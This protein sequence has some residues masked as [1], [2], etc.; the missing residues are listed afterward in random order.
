MDSP[1]FA[2][3][4]VALMLFFLLV[5]SH[6]IV[7][8]V[9]RKY[10]LR[11]MKTGFYPTV[12]VLLFRKKK[13]NTAILESIQKKNMVWPMVYANVMTPL[14]QGV[15]NLVLKAEGIFSCKKSDL[16]FCWYCVLVSVKL[17]VSSH[18]LCADLENCLL[19]L[20]LFL[21]VPNAAFL[22][23]KLCTF[24]CVKQILLLGR[25]RE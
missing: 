18:G 20:Q 11:K 12:I 24:S 22:C 2:P 10:Q 9:L 7:V 25:N 21:G 5:C 4:S 23:V 16:C 19:E 8:M 13:K 17:G 3:C 15:C 6:P 1:G 14:Q